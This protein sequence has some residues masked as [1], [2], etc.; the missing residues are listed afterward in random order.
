MTLTNLPET[1]F[2]LSSTQR[3]RVLPDGRIFDLFWTYDNA[4]AVYLNIHARESRDGGRT[5]L[6][7]WDTG[8]PGQPAP[9]VPLP[10]GRLVMVHVDRTGAPA[11]RCRVSRDQGRTWPAESG[12]TLYESALPS[13]TVRKDGMVDAGAEMGKFSVGLPATAALPDGDFL[14]VYYAGPSTDCTSVQ[15]ARCRVMQ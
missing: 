8:V 3:P 10:D 1:S 11:I 14:T 2:Q 4:A 9:V 5:W 13:Q 6:P 7:L 12:L 15:W